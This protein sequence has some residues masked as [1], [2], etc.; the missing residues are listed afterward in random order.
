LAPT[1]KV[2]SFITYILSQLLGVVI[3]FLR[4]TMDFVENIRV[5]KERAQTRFSAKQDRPPAILDTR[6]VSGIRIS[7]DAP[8]QG[9][10]LT[11]IGFLFTNHIIQTINVILRLLRSA[12]NDGGYL[13]SAIN[14]SNA[15]MC[16]C[17]GS[18]STFDLVALENNKYKVLPLICLALEKSRSSCF[19]E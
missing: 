3:L 16:N 15:L 18:S 13:T 19:S 5:S 12:R 10:E 17:F 2:F 1:G 11:M 9:N 14:T 6:I 7:E 8:A 4:V